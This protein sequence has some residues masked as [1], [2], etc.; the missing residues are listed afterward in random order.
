[1]TYCV[2]GSR[3]ACSVR[4]ILILKT[5]LFSH[6]V[7]ALRFRFNQLNKRLCQNVSSFP[8]SD[9]REDGGRGVKDMKT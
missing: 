5:P 9:K 8:L 7:D 3:F 4:D 1:M 2:F 6:F